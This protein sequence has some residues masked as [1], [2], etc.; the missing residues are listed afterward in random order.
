MVGGD[1]AFAGQKNEYDFARE[2][3]KE[4]MER[5]EIDEKNI[6]CV[7]ENHDVD[8]T[9]IKTCLQFLTRRMKL[10]GLK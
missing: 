8:Q 10:K 1:I 7:P 4:M 2:F 3:L 6:Y 5:L 9:L